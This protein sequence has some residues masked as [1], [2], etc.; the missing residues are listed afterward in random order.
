[1]L[2]R[3]LPFVYGMVVAKGALTII[4]SLVL[5]DRQNCA[6]NMAEGDGVLKTVVYQVRLTAKSAFVTVEES[7]ALRRV[8][9]QVQLGKSKLARSMEADEGVR[10]QGVLQRVKVLQLFVEDTVG[11]SDASTVAVRKELKAKR[12]RSAWSMPLMKN[13]QCKTN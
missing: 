13:Q 3:Q 6:K 1:M 11:E 2:S 8:A 12:T 4:V 9:C 5:E 10:L 7:A